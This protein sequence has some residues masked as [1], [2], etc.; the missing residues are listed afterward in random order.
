MA[1]QSVAPGHSTA[2]SDSKPVESGDDVLERVDR[3]P[4]AWL[5]L[6]RPSAYNALS[7][8]LLIALQSQLDMIA[9]DDSVRAV[10]IA[11]RGNAFCAGHDLREMR[12]E[13]ALVTYLQPRDDDDPAH[14]AAG[15]RAGTRVGDC[16]RLP[17]G[18]GL[19]S[20]GCR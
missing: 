10:V 15:D 16:G 5:W 17:A 3:G 2:A 20:G 1:N 12:A 7:E 8:D 14:A 9:S 19:R 6:N 18:G 11:A 13:P 4:V